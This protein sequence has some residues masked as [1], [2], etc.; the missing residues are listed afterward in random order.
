M[1]ERRRYLRLN[2]GEKAM[3]A[4]MVELQREAAA[5]ATE[6]TATFDDKGEVATFDAGAGEHWVLLAA[7]FCYTGGG[8]YRGLEGVWWQGRLYPH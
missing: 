1:K 2:Q 5:L 3:S 4:K 6:M 7:G 8:C